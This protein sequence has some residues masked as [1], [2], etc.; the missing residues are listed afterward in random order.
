MKEEWR[1]VKDF[2]GL[3][4]VS[5]FGRIKS[6]NKILKARQRKDGYLI[7]ALSKCGYAKNYYLH[8]LVAEAF[9]TNKSNL[10]CINHIDENKQNNYVY[11]LEWCTRSYNNNYGTARKRS[12]EKISKKVL[13]IETNTIF[14]SILEASKTTNINAANI[15]EVCKGCRKTAGKYHW[16]YL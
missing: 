3:Y 11:N 14:N 10:P 1:D 15:C 8:R 5:N 2:E 7:V 12:V 16:K 13:C 9:V 4:K 6:N